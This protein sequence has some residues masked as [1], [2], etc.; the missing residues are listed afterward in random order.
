MAARLW[1]R[2]EESTRHQEAE[3]EAAHLCQVSIRRRTL[4]PSQALEDRSSDQFSCQ[5][6]SHR[7]GCA[8]RGS[9]PMVDC[10][11]RHLRTSTARASFAAEAVIGRTDLHL[12]G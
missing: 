10:A 7:Q 6:P 11:G 2:E 8:F 1:P 4:R 9:N 12:Y 5:P 3:K